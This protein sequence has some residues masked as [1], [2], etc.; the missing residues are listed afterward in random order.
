MTGVHH[1]VALHQVDGGAGYVKAH[2][3]F[4]I[5]AGEADGVTALKILGK[6]PEVK[7]EAAPSEN[8]KGKRRIVVMKMSCGVSM[9]K[10]KQTQ[11]EVLLTG[12]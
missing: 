10:C 5:N 4:V 3:V 9:G 8:T 12:A 1:H 11:T 2:V 7:G 6:S